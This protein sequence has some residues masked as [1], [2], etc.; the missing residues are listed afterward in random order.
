MAPTSG[1]T[2]NKRAFST[3]LGALGFIF[4]LSITFGRQT[5]PNI[6]PSITSSSTA[7]IHEVSVSNEILKGEVIA[8]KIENATA[9][10]EL[11]RASWKTF[12]TMMAKFPDKPSQE[13]QTALF[14]Y[15]HL[16][17]RLYPW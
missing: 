6:I 2:L 4:L 15:I 1:I 17:A 13:E 8:G 14:S 10:A 16:F 5:S 7:L 12:H 9:K 11:G 3:I